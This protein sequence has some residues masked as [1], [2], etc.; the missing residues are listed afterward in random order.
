MIQAVCPEP[1]SNDASETE[2][3]G[4]NGVD[5]APLGGRGAQMNASETKTKPPQ[6]SKSKPALPPAMPLALPAVLAFFGRN[7][8]R[9]RFPDRETARRGFRVLYR[10]GRGVEIS[11]DFIFGLSAPEQLEL[12]EKDKIPFEVVR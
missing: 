6:S 7:W 12:L 8:K 11:G 3:A 2:R 9:I 4:T 10:S 1:D 5:S